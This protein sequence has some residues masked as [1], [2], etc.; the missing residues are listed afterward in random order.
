MNCP[1]TSIVRR[2]ARGFTLLEMV[3]AM[4]IM[5]GSLT[6]IIQ[7]ITLGQQASLEAQFRTEAV[8][9]AETKLQESLAGAIPLQ[10]GGGQVE[11]DPDWQWS[12][13]VDPGSIDGLLVATMTVTRNSK[14]ALGKHVYSIR[15]MV[16]DP[17]TFLDAAL[18]E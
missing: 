18:A 11:E 5:F 3:I 13:T 4:A 6:A 12:L 1:H 7:L 8:I 14:E 15:R 2:P 16:R 10:A 17:Q 9:Y